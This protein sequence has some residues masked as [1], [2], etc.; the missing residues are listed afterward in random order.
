MNPQ[1]VARAIREV[2]RDVA[3]E[4]R[5][6]LRRV[7][8]PTMIISREGDRVHPAELGR[9]LAAAHAERRADH[10]VGR[11]G[12]DGVDPDAGRSREGVPGRRRRVSDD[13]RHSPVARRIR[14]ASSL[15]S[16]SSARHGGAVRGRRDLRQAGAGRE[17]AV[18]DAGDP[19][20]GTVAAAPLRVAAAPAG[21]SC[22]RRGSGCR[23]RS[24]AR[25]GTGRR[26]RSTSAR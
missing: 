12:A 22:R 14:A 24:P 11:G 10:D 13:A 17:P 3:V 20:R 1:G 7:T 18:R 2:V 9:V 23:S 25:S 6:L 15:G 16:L 8:A 26:R 5:E 21:R 4:D 19:V